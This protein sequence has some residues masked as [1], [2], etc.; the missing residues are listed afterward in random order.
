MKIIIMVEGETE[1][2]FKAKLL[3]FIKR[4][5]I[6]KGHLARMPNL[7]FRKSDGGVPTH[8]KLKRAV[9]RFLGGN[10]PAAHVI[11]L[12]DVYIDKRDPH[13][14]WKTADEA[15]A[16]ARDWVGDEPKFHPHAALHDFEAWLLP[17]W[18]S[19]KKHARSN[20]RSPRG[21]PETI[22]HTTCPADVIKNVY[23]TGGKKKAYSKVQD[24]MAILRD[25]DLMVAIRA[26]P[27][28]RAFVHTIL[29]CAGV[30]KTVLAGMGF[31]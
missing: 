29:R 5:F 30:R 26:C 18:D 10:D 12:T 11:W 7:Q 3:E 22:N 27:E 24:S 25:Q 4:E 6:E 28:L 17:Y 2:A 14:Y 31:S 8:D 9:E 1:G 16:K 21:A 23:L 19:I 20:A 13:K 15:K